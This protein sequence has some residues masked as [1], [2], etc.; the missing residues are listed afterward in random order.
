MGPGHVGPQTAGMTE[1][2]AARPWPRNEVRREPSR[3]DRGA[4]GMPGARVFES[5]GDP[6]PATHTRATLGL[7]IPPTPVRSGRPP[8]QD[9][10]WRQIPPPFEA[11]LC[12]GA[13]VDWYRGSV[14]DVWGQGRPSVP[15]N[16]GE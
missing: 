9:P 13:V 1:E 8:A 4:I 15:R 3:P 14:A 6:R 16:A 7:R 11:P 5:L 12:G 2:P 10:G